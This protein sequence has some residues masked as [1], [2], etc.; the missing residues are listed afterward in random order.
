M[1]VQSKPKHAR[2]PACLGNWKILIPSFLNS[3]KMSQSKKERKKK[4]MKSTNATESTATKAKA[5]M[6]SFQVNLSAFN[7][8]ITWSIAIQFY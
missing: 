4:I 7:Y 2:G 8:N 3:F 1:G 5:I 6:K